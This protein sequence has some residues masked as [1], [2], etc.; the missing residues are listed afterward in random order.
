MRKALS[1]IS[2]VVG[3]EVAE[4]ITDDGLEMT[5][6]RSTDRN[7]KYNQKYFLRICTHI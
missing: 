5:N 6:M 1:L 3:D 7:E 2:M 4:K